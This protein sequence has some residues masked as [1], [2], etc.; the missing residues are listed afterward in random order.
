MMWT[1]FAI[2]LGWGFSAGLARVVYDKHQH[3]QSLQ[4]SVHELSRRN[5]EYFREVA[6]LK[7]QAKLYHTIIENVRKWAKT[8]LIGLEKDLPH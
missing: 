4:R 7:E 3:V 1:I 6:Q 8:S 5:N 2:A